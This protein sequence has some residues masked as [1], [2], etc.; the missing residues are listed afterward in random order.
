MYVYKPHQKSLSTCLVYIC[1]GTGLDE[2]RTDAKVQKVG[3]A[4]VKI[5]EIS[6]TVSF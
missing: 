6:G 4:L 2:I 3:E 5:F 1:A